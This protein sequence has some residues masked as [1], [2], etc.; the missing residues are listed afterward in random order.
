MQGPG[1]ASTVGKDAVNILEALEAVNNRHYTTSAT[2][3]VQVPEV[4]LGTIVQ[5][6]HALCR[7]Y[8]Y[9][10]QCAGTSRIM[11]TLQITYAVC[12]THLALR[13]HNIY[14]KHCAGTPC[15]M[16]TLQVP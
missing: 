4:L 8:M 5:A 9:H 16:Q 10:R 7:R 2:V 3:T 1:H 11:P 15:I 13:R 14:Y 6:Y 12:R